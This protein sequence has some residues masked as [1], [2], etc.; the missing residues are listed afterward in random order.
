MAST[1]RNPIEWSIDLLRTAT[2]HTGAVAQSLVGGEAE[3]LSKLPAVNRISLDDIR[4]AL[5]RG[6]DD[7]SAARTD[8]LALSVIYPIAGLA[9]W[10]FASNQDMLPLLF[11]LAS[12]FALLGPVVAVG[13]YEMSRQ[14]ELGKTVSWLDAFDV[15]RSPAFGSIIVLGLALLA[16][17]LLWLACAE[18]IYM[19]YL[20]PKPPVSAAAFLS[21]V[22]TTGAGRTMALVGLGTGFLFALLVF[23]ISAVSFPMLLDRNVGLSAAVVTSIRT[24]WENPV[25]MSIWGLIV[26]GGLLAG[27]LPLF[28]GLIV[29]VPVLG[30]ATWHLYRKLVVH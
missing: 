27:T 21:D 13:L 22:F 16:I 1:I 11:P 18:A 14:R 15:V 24:I 26:A 4:D 20:G 25:P 2:R 6:F 9:L 23:S 8:V 5:R 3:N 12:G 17:F 30:H 28:L 29:V 7:F 19:T 10:W